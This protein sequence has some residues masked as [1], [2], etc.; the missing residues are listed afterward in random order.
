MFDFLDDFEFDVTYLGVG[1]LGGLF[2][3]VFLIIDPF[4]S[5][6]D[7]LPLLYR[8]LSVIAAVPLGYFIGW[9]MIR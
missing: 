2:L 3:F 9:K 6:M 4:N 1:V 5:G 7:R 8:V